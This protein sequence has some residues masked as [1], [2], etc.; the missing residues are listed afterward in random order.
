MRRVV[1]GFWGPRPESA[2]ALADRWRQTLDGLAVL[3]PQAADAWSQVHADGPATAITA[4]GKAL[5]DAVRTAQSAADWS[6]LTGTGLRLVGT[7]APGW[8][9]EVSGLAGGRPEFLLQSLAVILHAPDDAPVPEEDILAL[10]ARVWEPDFGDVSDDDV[11]DALEDEAG[12][13]VGD[14]VVG[15]TGYLS[16]ARAALVPEDL[17]AVRQEL[18]GGGELLSIAAPGDSAAVVRAYE[19]LREAGALAP[20]PRPMDR[21]V[22]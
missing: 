11:L 20:L 2:D 6:D 3:V 14:P 17:A 7:G 12:Y 22:L 15:R 13:A 19:R 8:E 18:P 4:D 9:A 21:A 1:R 16:P 5:L 10:L